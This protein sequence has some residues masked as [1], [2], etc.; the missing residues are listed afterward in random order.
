[1]HILVVDDHDQVRSAMVQLLNQAGH[2]TCWSSSG[3]G[4]LRLLR[5]EQV[6]L[7]LLDM[8]LP[9]ISGWDVRRDQLSD[10]KTASIP[11]IVI[12]SLDV[13]MIR[14]PN[15]VNPMAT[16]QLVV[17]KPVDMEQLL[18]VIGHIGELAKFR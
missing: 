12:S 16:V 1:M 14:S 11:V 17:T 3:R 2:T 4:A 10:P 15:A 6:D 5:S 8:M 18:R 7:M 9:D 13:D